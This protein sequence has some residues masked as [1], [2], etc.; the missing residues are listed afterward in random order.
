MVT[1]VKNLHLQ[2]QIWAR[3]RRFEPDSQFGG[4]GPNSQVASSVPKAMAI[5]QAGLSSKRLNATEFSTSF[6]N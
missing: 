6:K 5:R 3:R 1:L 2:W 4:F